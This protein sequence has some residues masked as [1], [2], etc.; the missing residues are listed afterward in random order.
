MF[1]SDSAPHPRCRKEAC[2]CAAGVF[3]GPVALPK[4]AEIFAQHGALENL[5]AFVSDNA[6]KWY[7][8]NPVQKSITLQDVPMD[9]P[10]R[11]RS[12]G[13]EV[14]PMYAGESIGWSVV[15]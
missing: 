7:G 10:Q 1:G 5:Q 3:T 14:V 13:Q 12:Y 6:C 4:L 11:Y 9:V 15:R 8:L 2:G